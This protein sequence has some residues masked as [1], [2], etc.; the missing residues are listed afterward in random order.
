MSNLFGQ[1]RQGDGAKNPRLRVAGFSSA[2]IILIL[3][4]LGVVFSVLEGRAFLS[5]QNFLNIIVDASELLLM[6]VG[7][8]FVIITAGIDLSVGAVL[9]LS[10]VLAAKTMVALSGTSQQVQN[11]Q[12]P[13]EGTGIP[14]GIVVGLLVGLACGLINGL[15]VTRLKLTPFIA[16]LG[17]LGLFLG[18]AQILSGGVNVPYVPPAV[19]SQIGTRNLFGFLPVPIAVAVVVVIVAAL[20]LHLTRFGR[21][22]YAAGSNAEAARKVGINVDGHILKVYVLSGFLSGL[23]GVIDLARFNTAS[24]GAH[25]LD[26]LNVISAVVIGG[27]SLFGGL[28]TI[29]GSVVGTF[30]PAVLQN[31]F[32]I[33]GLQPFWQQA[34]I[35]LILIFAVFIDQKRRSAEQRQ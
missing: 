27:A 7:M 17:S 24:V 18:T 20:A 28:G 29:L 8:T 14:V 9:V 15:V 11:Y 35:G 3:L 10:S 13:H 31:G 5:T 22:T 34:A 26:N 33:Q 23:A 12:F 2:V 6:A 4:A 25:T 30:I 16:T 1:A 32:V 19:Q 21:Y